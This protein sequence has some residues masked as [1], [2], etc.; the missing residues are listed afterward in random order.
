LLSY[1]TIQVIIDLSLVLGIDSSAAQA[2]IK[3]R[4]SLLSQFY[5]KLSIFVSGSDDG[6]PCEIN[7]SE[8]LTS[9]NL[10]HDEKHLIEQDSSSSDLRFVGS[11][12]CDDLDQA[13]IY[14]EVRELFQYILE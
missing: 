6:F 13:L 10:P 14:A 7:L 9:Q 11:H 1:I 3:L 4:D 2:M 5:I 12:V 8:V